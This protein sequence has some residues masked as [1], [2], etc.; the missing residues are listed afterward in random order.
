MAC[1]LIISLSGCRTA[2]SAVSYLS[3]M[4][5]VNWFLNFTY[6][7][8]PYQQFSW[9]IICI[10]LTYLCLWVYQ[11]EKVEKI[12]EGTYGVVYKARDRVTNETIALKKIRLEQEDEGV[13]STAIR[14]ISLLKEMQ[15]GNIVRWVAAGVFCVY[16]C[17]LFLSFIQCFGLFLWFFHLLVYLDF[18]FSYAIYDTYV[19][20]L[21]L[22]PCFFFIFLKFLLQFIFHLCWD[23]LFIFSHRLQ[24][25]VHSEKRLYLVFEYLDLDLKKH[26]DSSPD[27]AKDLRLIKVTLQ[28]FRGSYILYCGTI[29][30]SFEWFKT[31]IN[32]SIHRLDL[33]SVYDFIAAES[34]AE[35]SSNPQI[36]SNSSYSIGEWLLLDIKLG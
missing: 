27:F 24:D 19:P 17:L 21:N 36:L 22:I 34:C 30:F 2:R 6:D 4:D 7:P 13:P 10:L 3:W 20:Y 23:I 26:M 32:L 14:E 28:S 12:G 15:H 18:S 25:V 8:V 35:F 33:V 31:L 11:Y 9:Y 5:Q 29:L 1:C 16:I